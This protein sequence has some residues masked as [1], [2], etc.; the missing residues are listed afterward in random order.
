MKQYWQ[1][2]AVREKQMLVG[3]IAF[4]LIFIGYAFF[5]S[6]FQERLVQKQQEAQNQKTLLVWMQNK[7]REVE[8]LKSKGQSSVKQLDRKGQSLLGLTD[9]S[10]REQGLAKSIKRIQ[11]R[12]NAGVQVWLDTA[13]FD[14]VLFWLEQLSHYGVTLESFK[15]RRQ[16]DAGTVNV[17][18]ILLE[19]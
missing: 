18:V 17:E 4:L 9:K 7:V 19:R 15:A 3:G 8:A 12:S 14:Q 11:P 10:A 2:L 5:W 16:S 13:S 6:P 1:N